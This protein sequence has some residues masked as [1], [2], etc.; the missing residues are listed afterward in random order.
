MEQ[1]A[2]DVRLALRRLG[3][4]PLF[5]VV[6]ILTLTLGI[7]ATTSIF[8][9]V[10][11]FL[12]RPLPV[13]ESSEILSLSQVQGG[14]AFPTLSYP[15]YRDIR[16]RTQ[17]LSGVVAFRIIM[18]SIGLEGSSQRAWGYLVS[19]NYFDVLGIKAARG[20][21]LT[22][23]DD[24]RP[25]AHP[26]AV[27]SYAAWQSRFG[28]DEGLVGRNVRINAHKFTIIGVA[29][30]GFFGTE[31]YMAPDLFVPIMM[32]KDLEGGAGYLD[33]RETS[34][35]F[36]AGRRKPGNTN[37]QAEAEMNAIADQLAEEYPKVNGAMKIVITPPGLAGTFLRGAAISFTTA[38]FGVSGLV[39]L[40]ACT[41]LA[42]ML[43]SRAS[44][45][46]K[47][48]AIRLALGGDR[49]RIVRQ[50]LTESLVVALAGG[51][52]GVLLAIW[53][54]DGLSRWRP[55]IDLPLLMNITPDIRVFLF[56]LLLSVVTTFAF[57][58]LPALQST[59][60]DLV[61]A[62]KNGVTSERFRKWTLRDFM[63]TAQVA[64][65]AL[66][67]VCSLL[68][69][70]SLQRSLHAPIGFNPAGAVTASF[71][72]HLHG[73]GTERGQAF[74]KRL[75]DDIRAMPGVES[76]ALADSIPLSLNFNSDNIYVEGKAKPKA[77]ESPV[78]ATYR[79]SPD[80]FRTM[81]TRM[82]AGREFQAY[83]RKGSKRVAIVNRVFAAQL[84]GG[85]AIGKR[86]AT[87]QDSPMREIVGIVEDGKHFSLAEAPRPAFYTPLEMEPSLFSTVV[88]RANGGEAE[89][90][91][92]VQEAIRRLDPEVAPFAV[93]TLSQHLETPLFP[94]RLAAKSLGFFGVL[95]IILAAT[96]IY[97]V[98]AYAVSSR[99]RE[100]GI[101]MAIGAT[102]RNVLGLVGRRSL[103]LVGGGILLGLGAAL[104]V[105]TVFEA[106]LYGV[107]ATDPI[108]LGMVLLLMVAVTVT[109]CVLPALRAVRIQPVSALRQD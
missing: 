102:Q 104:R 27:L 84:V 7:G 60:T 92:R 67:L 33:R 66:L 19:G 20:R 21:L 106:V 52:G 1:F 9:A 23:D 34:N 100:I 13:R 25:G 18:A 26:V 76:A 79:V 40:L 101:R 63:V 99:T 103:A 109:A 64:L 53:V 85:D 24:R 48:M 44:D 6:A 51:L 57:G 72:L 29:P 35:T 46:R 2:A 94:A 37:G 32:Q 98:M 97:G 69:V 59:R 73:Y 4:S 62:L 70:R 88:V 55:P 81:R 58:L 86:F 45:R 68:V 8:S 42:S 75:I 11:A 83:D 47:E 108:V 71:D 77:A 30:E 16:D 95:A 15:N 36:V 78:A 93:G 96:G 14:T 90:V 74:Q 28:G 10:D 65:S 56:A 38:L 43:L 61:P 107:E 41:N 89:M 50:L 80:Y 82:L 105:G 12:L 91:K 87:G 31:V 22:E 49:L 39:L 3:Q 54:T 5:T 17:T